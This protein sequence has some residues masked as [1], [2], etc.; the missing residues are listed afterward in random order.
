MEIP[1]SLKAKHFLV[2]DDY[3]SMR[4]LVAEQL[5]KL[6]V[7]KITFAVSGNEAFKK[8]TE[9]EATDP[10]QYILVDLVMENGTGVELVKNVREN[11]KKKNLPIVMITSKAEISYVLE[12]ARVGVSSY[13]V[14]PWEETEFAKKLT[15]S[16]KN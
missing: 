4:E 16:D 9:L 10:I 12:A 8:I 14:K 15:D 3:E 11:L 6:G 7:T 13:L 2:V 5:K 1:A